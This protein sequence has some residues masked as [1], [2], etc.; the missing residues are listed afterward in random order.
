[1]FAKENWYLPIWQN[2]QIT[3]AS[4][5]VYQ[6]LYGMKF[7][8]FR[9]GSWLKLYN[10]LCWIARTLNQNGFIRCLSFDVSFWYWWNSSIE[11]ILQTQGKK[12]TRANIFANCVRSLRSACSTSINSALDFMKWRVCFQKGLNPMAAFLSFWTS[13]GSLNGLICE[14][15]LFRCNLTL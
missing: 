2:N 1:M 9:S 14:F 6:L 5:T 3:R 7:S 11:F 13:S 15:S 4:M 8:L 10:W 12:C